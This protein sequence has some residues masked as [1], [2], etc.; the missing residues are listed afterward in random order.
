MNKVFVSG[1]LAAPVETKP[2]GQ[3]TLY[4]LRVRVTEKMRKDNQWTTAY[5]VIVVEAWG[6]QGQSA[7]NRAVGSPITL[8]GKIK[9]NS[10]EKNGKQYEA[11]KIQATNIEEVESA[12]P[13]AYQAQDDV[14]F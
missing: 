9:P 10:W 4:T 7:M 3:A 13:Q 1:V 11:M 6:A 8:E 14:P 5:P 12:Q 2:I